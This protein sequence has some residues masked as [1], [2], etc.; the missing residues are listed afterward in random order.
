M[1]R[2]CLDG[3][4]SNY[5]DTHL[6]SDSHKLHIDSLPLVSEIRTATAE[7]NRTNRLDDTPA[8][9]ELMVLAHKWRLLQQRATQVVAKENTR[10]GV[11]KADTRKNL[12]PKSG[13]ALGSTQGAANSDVIRLYSSHSGSRHN[14]FDAAQ[15]LLQPEPIFNVSSG[16]F[17]ATRHSSSGMD[18][19]SVELGRSESVF[20]ESPVPQVCVALSPLSL[21]RAAPSPAKMSPKR[22]P[23]I[24][25]IPGSP[26]HQRPS[27]RIRL[28]NPPKKKTPHTIS[29]GATTPKPSPLRTTVAFG[30]SVAPMSSF[31]RTT[32][33]AARYK[34]QQKGTPGKRARAQLKSTT[35]RVLAAYSQQSSTEVE[36]T[37]S[38]GQSQVP[39]T[40]RVLAGFSAFGRQGTGAPTG[41]RKAK[42]QSAFN[43]DFNVHSMV[44][45]SRSAKNRESNPTQSSGDMTLVDPP[46][47]LGNSAPVAK[48]RM[49]TRLS[50]SAITA[51]ASEPDVHVSGKTTPL[52]PPDP[53]PVL[54]AVKS[55]FPPAHPPR[56]EAPRRILGPRPLPSWAMSKVPSPSRYVLRAIPSPPSKKLSALHD[57]D[58]DSTK[59]GGTSICSTSAAASVSPRIHSGPSRHQIRGSVGADSC[60]DKDEDEFVDAPQDSV[61][62]DRSA[63]GGAASGL[64]SHTRQERPIPQNTLLPPSITKKPLAVN[65]TPGKENVRERVE[66]LFA[67]FKSPLR[68]PLGTLS[69]AER[70][71][72]AGMPMY[73]SPARPAKRDRTSG[74]SDCENANKEDR[75]LKKAKPLALEAP[76]PTAPPTVAQPPIA[77]ASATTPVQAAKRPPVK[78]QKFDVPQSIV[79]LHGGEIPDIPDDDEDDDGN[80]PGPS[81]TTPQWAKS[82]NVHEALIR[83]S[84]SQSAESIFGRVDPNVDLEAIFGRPLRR[85]AGRRSS[86]RWPANDDTP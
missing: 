43:E 83:Q 80:S 53:P 38:G 77:F 25:S 22:Q 76:V 3:A 7:W 74:A 23:S 46:T 85:G 31:A 71:K 79:E 8:K 15:T 39:K 48:T 84:S 54:I 21:T 14:D 75:I 1:T 16:P 27:K 33:A 62:T 17:D 9:R 63:S 78:P 19:I 86:V 35:Q 50:T 18:G 28:N 24:S 59:L 42:Q 67:S 36:N 2:N 70:I 29:S 4:I 26:L 11:K 66:Q 57:V 55:V 47:E 44:D 51:D 13:N 40:A 6:T 72:N 30:T 52:D 65:A 34:L 41:V 64:F 12:G 81:G 32:L 49:S 68:P 56:N 61:E 37:S 45:G 60:T 58:E 73:Q 20:C 5:V 82:M 69:F 10:K